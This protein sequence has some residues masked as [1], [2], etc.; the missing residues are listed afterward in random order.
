[1]DH[2]LKLL[3]NII[4][5][6][7]FN[8]IMN[9]LSS[10]KIKNYIDVGAHEGEFFKY[11]SKKNKFLKLAVLIEPQTHLIKTLLK[12]PRKKNLRMVIINIALGRYNKLQRIFINTLSSTSTL[13][14]YNNKSFWL[15]FKILILFFSRSFKKKTQQFIAVKTLDKVIKSLQL[16]KIDFIKIDAE[17]SEYDV[18]MGSRKCFTKIKYIL[19]EKQYFALYKNYSFQKIERELLNKNFILVKRFIF[20][21]PFFEDRLYKNLKIAN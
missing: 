12:L 7:Y 5:K 6:Y 2:F 18:L 14:K 3:I 1:M 9:N 8:N 19:I 16:K 11:F 13:K 20:F 21:L 15:I 10:L 4:N 17:G